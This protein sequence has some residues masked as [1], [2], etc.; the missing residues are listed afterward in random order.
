M[1]NLN[2]SSRCRITYNLRQ[3]VSI[4]CSI[5]DIEYVPT[6]KTAYNLSAY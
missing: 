3:N 6:R 2:T 1:A 4:F 5:F